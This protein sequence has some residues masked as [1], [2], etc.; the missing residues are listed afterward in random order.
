MISGFFNGSTYKS[1]NSLFRQ[2]IFRAHLHLFWTKITRKCFRL[3]VLN[4]S[5]KNGEVE[6]STY[7]GLQSV[8][9]SLIRG[10]ENKESEFDQAFNPL[11]ERNRVK[12]QELARKKM[13]GTDLP[14]VNLVKI[15]DIYYVRDGHHRISVSRW[16]GQTFVDAE[17]TILKI[18]SREYSEN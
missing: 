12:W 10:T 14:P 7:A 4:D 5:L 8:Q 11:Q 2:A 18:H 15:G 1:E 6:N 3:K 16:L 13:R 17:I 9:I